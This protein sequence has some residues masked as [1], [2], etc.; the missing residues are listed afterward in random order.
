M[1][2]ATVTV[3]IPMSNS[4]QLAVAEA[5]N[6]HDFQQ[7]ELPETDRIPFSL[8]H[9]EA[10][11]GVMSEL[12]NNAEAGRSKLANTMK[13]WHLVKDELLMLVGPGYEFQYQQQ[14]SK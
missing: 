7:V 3:T 12:Y 8:Q 6:T 2:R 10:V 4:T 1:T 14:F 13:G 11:K 9:I 5:R